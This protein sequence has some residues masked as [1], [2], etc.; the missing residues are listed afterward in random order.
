MGCAV[1]T[2]PGRASA[3]LA[4]GLYLNTVPVRFA[5]TGGTWADLAQAAAAAERRAQPH[6]HYPLVHIVQRLGRP[7]FDVSFNF[8]NFHVYRDLTALKRI[9]SGARWVAGKPG[10]PL[11]L[12]FE[13]DD[14]DATARIIIEYDVAL[15]DVA[16]ADRLAGLC[17]DALDAAGRDPWRTRP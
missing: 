12:D 5:T 1:N 8:S 3:E 11:I 10:F 4:V 16:R 14:A 17:R 7:A 2:R 13:V 6:L 9:R 15:I